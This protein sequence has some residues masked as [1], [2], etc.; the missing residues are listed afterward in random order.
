MGHAVVLERF[1]AVQDARGDDAQLVAPGV[2]GDLELQREQ[3]GRRQ[4]QAG[5][6]RV[7][8]GRFVDVDRIRLASGLGEERSCPASAVAW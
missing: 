6:A 4:R 8:R 3:E 7:A 1:L 5:V 2:R